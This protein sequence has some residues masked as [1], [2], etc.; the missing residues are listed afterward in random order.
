V[1]G[2]IMCAAAGLEAVIA[3][4]SAVPCIIPPVPVWVCIGILPALTAGAAG[5]Q[6]AKT[7]ARDISKNTLFFI[8]ERT[9]L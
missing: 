8:V 5:A 1:I 9:S 2:S 3:P 6:A 7:N 4:G